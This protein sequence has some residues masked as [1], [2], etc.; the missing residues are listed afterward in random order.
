MKSFGLFEV[1]EPSVEVMSTYL[2]MVVSAKQFHITADV[3]RRAGVQSRIIIHRGKTMIEA[4][5]YVNH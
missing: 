3:M 5:T 1:V 4:R 2:L